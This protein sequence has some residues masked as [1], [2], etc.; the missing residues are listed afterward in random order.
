MSSKRRGPGTQDR[1]AGKKDR[2]RS[3]APAPPKKKRQ[4]Q[5]HPLYGEIPLV[6]D[7]QTYAGV[8]HSFLTWDPD[9]EPP[10]PVGAVRGDIR[11]Q[12]MGGMCFVPRYFYLDEAN[13]CIQ[14]GADFVFTAAAQKFW[15]ETLGGPGESFAVR[16]LPCRRQRRTPRVLSQMILAARQN[17]EESPSDTTRMLSLAWALLLF[18]ERTGQGKEYANEAISLS[19]KVARLSPQ[20]CQALFL[21]G[22]SHH[23][24][25]RS[26]KAE[27]LLRE[28][29]E[30][31]GT[32]QRYRKLVREARTLLGDSQS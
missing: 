24:D 8:E 1:G 11:R 27:E 14:C 32:R 7:K 21:E 28:F 10:F 12:K 20:L 22:K 6:E 29:I 23:L 2:R 31:A 9:Y 4:V 13:T 19:R 15:Y 16:C 25:G 30:A 5:S 26:Q 18:R 17:L 3:S